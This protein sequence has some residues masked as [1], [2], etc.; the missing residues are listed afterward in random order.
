MHESTAKFPLA[1]VYTQMVVAPDRITFYY[2]NYAQLIKWISLV[3]L[4]ATGSICLLG[5]HPWI[6]TIASL[7]FVAAIIGTIL[8][9]KLA[10]PTNQTYLVVALNQSN[11]V[12]PE[13][14]LQAE[15]IEAVEV[16][17]VPGL[18]SDGYI[19]LY[20]DVK[21]E[22]SIL[23]TQSLNCSTSRQIMSSQRIRLLSAIA[24]HGVQ[25]AHL[26]IRN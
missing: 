3:I 6:N 9:H 4:L 5:N 25:A 19:G 17:D 14:T 12:L 1:G 20:I 11:Q 13:R 2:R 18:E 23:L 22:G 21:D 7:V 15:R 8:I 26:S 24:P 10:R 16:R